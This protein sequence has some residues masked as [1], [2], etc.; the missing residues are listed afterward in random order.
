VLLAKKKKIEA[1]RSEKIDFVPYLKE[2][3][4]VSLGLKEELPDL[5]GVELFGAFKS[6]FILQLRDFSSLATKN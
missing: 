1:N 5:K 3:E 6:F 2:I 4:K